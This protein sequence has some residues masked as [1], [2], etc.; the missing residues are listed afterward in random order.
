MISR[1]KG[2]VLTRDTDRVEV[3]TPGGIVYEVSVPLTVAS[4]LPAVGQDVEILTAYVLRED[5]AT[6]FGFLDPS[7]RDLFRR[8]MVTKGVGPKTALSL[9]STYTAA[10]LARA[11]AERDVSALMQVSG[12]GKK[13]AERMVVEL[14]DNVQDL[15]VGGDGGPGSEARKEAVSALVALGYSFNEADEA[16]TQAVEQGVPESTEELIRRALATR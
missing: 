7:E 1:L 4:R 8:V 2:T 16:V 13:T 14:A 11:L 3:E 10:R 5:S 12:I 9:L 15:A 6:L